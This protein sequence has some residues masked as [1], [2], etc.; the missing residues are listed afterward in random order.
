MLTI[1]HPFLSILCGFF[2][3]IGFAITLIGIILA[4]SFYKL[5]KTFLDFNS[6]LKDWLSYIPTKIGI[7]FTIIGCLLSVVPPCLIYYA[8]NH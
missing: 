6:T 1:S 2:F 4:T 7:V 8:C 5:S 3:F